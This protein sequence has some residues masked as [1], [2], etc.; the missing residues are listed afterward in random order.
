MDERTREMVIELCEQLA[1]QVDKAIE[2]KI[3]EKSAKMIRKTYEA[4]LKEGFTPSQATELCQG[5]NNQA[6][7]K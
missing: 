5:F 3:P 1:L 7:R 2:L 4:L 6:S